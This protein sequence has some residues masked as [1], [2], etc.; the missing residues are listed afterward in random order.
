[1]AWTAPRTWV[2]SEVVTAALMNTHVRDNLLFLKSDPVIASGTL[3]ALQQHNK[4]GFN[5]GYTEATKL[6]LTSIAIPADVGAVYCELWAISAGYSQPPA[7]G[8]GFRWEVR[9][10]EATAGNVARTYGSLSSTTTT[11]GSGSYPIYLRSPDLAWAGTTRTLNLILG[12][13]SCM[14]ELNGTTANPIYMR[15]VRSY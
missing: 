10:D 13:N 15:I 7:S 9:M 6:S 14:G 12:A 2:V 4:V 11:D 1:M 5:T 8:A 3:T